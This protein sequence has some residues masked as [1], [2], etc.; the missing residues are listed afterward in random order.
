MSDVFISYSRKDA[1]F[2]GQLEV[3]LR[4]RGKHVWVDTGGIGPGTEW[5]QEIRL[6]L[7]ACDGLVF[8]ISLDSLTSGECGKELEQARE[9]NKRVVPVLYREPNG[10][11]VP[12][13][14]AERNFVLLR[15]GDDF[16]AGISKLIEA[17]DTDID[18]VNAHTRLGA[19]A[20]EWEAHKRNGAYQLR[21]SDLSDADAVLT[22]A[23]G[24]EPQP[25]AVQLEY[26]AA[27]RGAARRRQRTLLSSVAAAL[28][29]A[30]GLAVYALIERSSAAASAQRA[31]SRQL[32]AD[33]ETQL[34]IDPELSL[35]LASRAYDVSP[36]AESIEVLRQALATSQ[37]RMTV[38]PADG[39]SQ[40]QMTPDGRMLVTVGRSDALVRLWPP[41]GRTARF[42]FGR[43]RTRL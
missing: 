22:A 25:S 24:K 14:L 5:R 15:T 19:R 28:V 38:H 35:L 26:V 41:L 23:A 8:V 31:Y 30:I 29:I 16:E 20:S 13:E 17:L 3:A 36:T 21:G 34:G 4:A 9:L 42:A 10:V 27:S 18:W 32:A 11:A 33:A 7:E 6:G 37:I 39:V 43:R 2:V 40:A 1:T 12:A